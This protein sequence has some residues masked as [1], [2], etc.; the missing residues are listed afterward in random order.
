[1]MRSHCGFSGL[2]LYVGK[3]PNRILWGSI[4]STLTFCNPKQ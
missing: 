4:S 1:M 3:K 2:F